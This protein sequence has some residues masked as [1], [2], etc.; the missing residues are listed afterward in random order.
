MAFIETIP[1]YQAIGDVRAMYQRYENSLGYVPNYAKLFSQHPQV[2]DTWSDLLASIRSRM[3]PRRYEL[4]TLAAAGALRSSYCSLAHGTILRQKFY[5]PEEL[6]A[7]V[8]DYTTAGLAPAEVAMIAFASQMIWD[9][10]TITA[11]DVDE[12]RRYGFTDAEIFDVAA[13]AAARS[14]FSKLLDALGAEP[15]A[16]YLQ[17]ENGLR[18]QLTVGRPISQ[19][20]VERL[21]VAGKSPPPG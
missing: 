12:L 3:D 11:A 14:F 8:G 21:P 10:T 4:V 20:P 17:L 9:A 6:A 2:M 15:D 1:V 16:A 5:T 19:A 18:Q 13:T 7:I